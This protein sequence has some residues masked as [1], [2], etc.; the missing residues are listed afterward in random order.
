[1][2]KLLN[3]HNNIS[4]LVFF[5]LILAAVRPA[6]S[7]PKQIEDMCQKFDL[8]FCAGDQQA[9][10]DGEEGKKPREFT[11]T[12][13]EVLTRLLEQQKKLKSRELELERRENQLKS[14]QE[15]IQRQIAQLEKLQQEIER[16]IEA[17]KEQDNEQLSKAVAFYTKMDPGKAAQSIAKLNRKIAVQI[18]LKLKDKQASEILANMTPEQSA[19]L[20]EIIA[21]KK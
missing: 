13:R 4:L 18:L 19:Q 17:K 9:S 7:I 5:V 15:D 16:D 11:E 21:S 20:I 3:F 8:T 12:E 14:L 1:M 2:A 6:Y 10:E